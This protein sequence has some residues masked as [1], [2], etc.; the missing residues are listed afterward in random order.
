MLYTVPQAPK[1]GDF[2]SEIAFNSIANGIVY[3]RYPSGSLPRELKSYH[4][5]AQSFPPR[6]SN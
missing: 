5:F 4:V 2:E 6:G 1:C 3:V